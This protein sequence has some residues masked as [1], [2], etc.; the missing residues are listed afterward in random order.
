MSQGVTYHRSGTLETD[1]VT[2]EDLEFDAEQPQDVKSGRSNDTW[3]QNTSNYPLMVYVSVN[4]DG[5]ADASADLRGDVNTTQSDNEIIKAESQAST[6]QVISESIQ[7]IVPPDHYY[8]ANWAG[9]LS[10][11]FEQKLGAA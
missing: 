8:K 4:T 6:A 11:W 7:F 9:T 10:L 2:T 3:E 5:T 1:A